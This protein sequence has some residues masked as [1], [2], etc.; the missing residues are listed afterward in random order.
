MLQTNSEP[1]SNALTRLRAA[2][3]LPAMLAP[4]LLLSAPALAQVSGDP[5]AGTLD[6]SPLDDLPPYIRVLTDFG[7]RP[8]W[9]PDGERVVFIESVPLGEVFEVEVATGVTRKLTGGF[10]HIGFSRA[11]YLPT[12][13]LLLCGPTSG[14]RPSP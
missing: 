4:L 12:G 1:S 5:E 9:S 13:D 6:G 10:G 11:Q 8:D 7:A 3:I 2:V 14:P